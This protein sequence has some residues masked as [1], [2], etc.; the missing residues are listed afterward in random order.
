IGL[1]VV[2]QKKIRDFIK[3]YNKERQTTIILTSHY[4]EDIEQLCK[5]I[6]IIDLGKIIYDG[7]LEDLIV[8]YVPN[9]KVT[10]YFEQE[11]SKKDVEKFG[12]I[13]AFEPL[14]VSFEIS[15]DKVKD[16]IGKILSSDLVVK[17]IEIDEEDVESI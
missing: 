8:K 6:V 12:A 11:I 14:K 9:K 16:M 7:P 4:M 13:S 1:D 17:D 15:R 3:K 5:R 2:A 10:I